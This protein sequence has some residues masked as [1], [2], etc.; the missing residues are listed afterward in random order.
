M[1]MVENNEVYS[2]DFS[3]SLSSRFDLGIDVALSGIKHTSVCRLLV[4]H[5]HGPEQ[6]PLWR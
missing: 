6:A 2:H 3:P 4:G 5:V 1:G